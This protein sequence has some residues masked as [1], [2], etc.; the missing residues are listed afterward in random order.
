VVSGVQARK[1]WKPV[2]VDDHLLN[3]MGVFHYGH[4]IVDPLSELF[5]DIN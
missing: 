3:K 1:L 4:T 2:M 5:V